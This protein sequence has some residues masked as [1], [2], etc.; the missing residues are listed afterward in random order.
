VQKLQNPTVTVEAVIKNRSRSA[1]AVDNILVGV[2]VQFIRENC[3]RSSHDWSTSMSLKKHDASQER[4][5]E[6]MGM[7]IGDNTTRQARS[8]ILRRAGAARSVRK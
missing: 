7:R 2:L 8:Q 4:P 6:M 5:E 1:G 3:R